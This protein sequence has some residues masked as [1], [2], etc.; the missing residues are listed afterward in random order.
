MPVEPP[1]EAIVSGG[2][3]PSGLR[4]SRLTLDDPHPLGGHTMTV[5]E[6]D[7]VGVASAGRCETALDNDTGTARSRTAKVIQS[8]AGSKP[9]T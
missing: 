4:R 5:D 1:I 9:A 3:S 6:V 7:G 2:E 8:R